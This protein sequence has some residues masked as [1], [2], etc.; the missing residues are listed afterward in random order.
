MSVT[1]V[2]GGG[3]V[4]FGAF[5]FDAPTGRLWRGD[6]EVALRPKTAA[7]LGCLVDRP[8]DVVSKRQL[9]DTVWPEG[10]VGDA[11]VTVC[12]N[13][14]RQIFGDDPRRPRFIVTAHRRGYRF[15]APVS[16]APP[17]LADIGEA[18][19]SLFV[20]RDAELAMLDEWWQLA[21]G[22]QRQVVFIAAQAGVGKTALVEAFTA[23]LAARQRPDIAW[24][25]SLEQVGV[26]EAYLPVL[27]ALS[28]LG[29]GPH[30]HH[31]REVLRAVAPAWLLQLP[32]LLEPDDLESLPRQTLGASPERM[33]REVGDALAEL[34]ADRS[35]VLVC[36]DLHHGDRS[37]IDLLAYLARRREP[38]RLL[39]L[40]TYRPAEIVARSHPLRQVVQDLRGRRL[41]GFLA[42][43]LLTRQ[44]VATYVA[45]RMA[46]AV[47]SGELVYDVHGRTSGNA[48]FL[49]RLVDYLVDRDLLVGVSGELHG[50]QPL[51]RL[52]IPDS[53]RQF[54]ERQLDELA[55]DDRALVEAAS[56]AG[57]EFATEAVYAAARG[58]RTDLSASAVEERFATL[59]RA[60]GVLAEAGLGEWPDG[61][62]TARYRFHHALYHEVLYSRLPPARRAAAHVRIGERL[63][64][65]FGSHTGEI[66]A[67][68]A[69]HFER[70]REYERAVRHL[71]AAAERAMQRAA[72]REALAYATRGLDV[73]ERAG[74]FTDRVAVE[75]RLRMAQTVSMV[76]LHGVGA[77]GVDVAY[78]RARAACSEIDDPTLLAPV[79]YGLWMFSVNQRSVGGAFEFSSELAELALRH[80]DPVLE[81]QAHFIA[82]S[83]EWVAGRP[84]VA[85]PSLERALALYEPDAHRYLALTYG[86]D[87]AVGC[88]RTA[89]VVCWE[90]GYPDQARDHAGEACRLA[91]ELGYPTAVAQAYSFAIGT[92]I[93]CRDPAGA[94]ER[95]E[96]L[97]RVAERFEMTVFAAI[98]TTYR[99][100]VVA[101]EGDAAA[102]V[103]QMREGLAAFAASGTQGGLHWLTALL[104]E[105]LARFGDLPAAL[106]TARQALRNARDSGQLWYEPEHVRLGGVLL[107]ATE[108]ASRE[109]GSD[110]ALAE[111]AFVEAHDIARREQA[112]SFELRAATSLARLWHRT[113]ETERARRV[114][115][116]A[117]G[118][119]TEGHD[120]GDLREAAALLAELG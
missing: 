96:E 12:V 75:L 59:A 120:T 81:L 76:T 57:T 101:H 65:G 39:V 53:V 33:L 84:L 25:Q 7:V 83:N 70:G 113:G 34:T 9:L 56:V 5:R 119:F 108:D 46:P 29:R 72:P 23:R 99:G 8:G 95:C 79:L 110:T 55:V 52:G 20:G 73:L 35:L 36:E 87:P 47:P 13:E 64:A 4:Y 111:A 92:H 45:R 102:G 49:T 6:D 19:S 63:T 78:Q 103:A 2:P 66:A 17:A 62:V 93:L 68:L 117:Y 26:G 109:P 104:A 37:T 89:A 69:M 27:D 88:H 71:A 67:E 32:S 100:W 90:L 50:R 74:A 31:V 40:C 44:A 98:A 54:I 22:G 38:A 112:K 30:G 116:D 61:T 42:L 41:C 118:W 10:F 97:L 114:L 48:L 115:G 80:R 106:E 82:G 21:D 77:P 14:L 24:G 58:E 11:V 28:E 86:D 91:E 51:D 16:P 18:S 105:A 94:G 43:E 15:V 85:L 3:A 1:P 107:L 60:G